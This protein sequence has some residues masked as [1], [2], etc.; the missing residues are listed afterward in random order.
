MSQVKMQMTFVGKSKCA[1]KNCGDTIE[2]NLLLFDV[3][4]R[5]LLKAARLVNQFTR[6][7]C[8]THM[9]EIKTKHK[10]GQLDKMKQILENPERGYQEFYGDGG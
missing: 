10:K 4:A 8:N 7:Y 9:D 6:F 1:Y 5:T 3:D 2:P